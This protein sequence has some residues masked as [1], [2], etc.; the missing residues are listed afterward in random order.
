MESNP[1][2]YWAPWQSTENW[3]YLGVIAVLLAAAGLFLRRDRRLGFLAALGALALLGMLG[4]FSVVFSWIQGLLPAFD[5]FRAAG[6]LLLLLGLANGALAAFGLDA[7]L[8]LLP[9]A[10]VRP[11]PVAPGADPPGR[12]EALLGEPL[13][14]D[15]P[16][17]PRR[18]HGAC[19]AWR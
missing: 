17:S 2:N 14:E 8:R 5:R 12:Y 4:P 10:A 13:P 16:I 18:T 7:L 3:G 9:A 11:T 15:A 1:L 6:R 19:A